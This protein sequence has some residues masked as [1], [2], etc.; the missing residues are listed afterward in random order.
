[1]ASLLADINKGGSVTSGLRKV[2]DDMK[3]KNRTERSGTVPAAPAAAAALA[4]ATAAAPGGRAKGGPVGPPRIECE[5]GRK[6]VI[7][8]QVG[9]REIVI[10]QT[11]PRQTVYIYN[12][13][14]STIQVRGKVNAITMDKCSRTGLLFE[15]VVATCEL[16]NSSSVEVQCTGAVPTVAVDKCDGCQLYLPRATF[17]STDITTAKSS[18]VNVIVPGETEDAEPQESAIPEQFVSRYRGGRWVTESVAHSGA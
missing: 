3:T 14:G 5:Q 8:N 4:P 17:E 12:C 13:S 10:D 1:M 18:E 7:E 9:N 11:E 15:Q 6:W 16:V 2:T